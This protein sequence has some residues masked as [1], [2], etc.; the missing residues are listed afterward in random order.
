MNLRTL[1]GTVGTFTLVLAVVVSAAAAGPA[2]LAPEGTTTDPG[3]PSSFSPAST[4]VQTAP[5]SGSVRVD[6][7]SHGDVVVLDVAHGNDQ[8]AEQVRTLE[9]VLVENGY[10]VRFHGASSGSTAA[11]AQ[12]GSEKPELN[13]SLRG[14]D[15]YVVV[16]PAQPFTPADATSVERFAEAGGRVLVLTDPKSQSLAGVLLTSLFG[17]SLD[18]SPSPLAPMSSRHGL[19]VGSGYLYD[20]DTHDGNFQTVYAN[21]ASGTLARGVDRV[22]LHRAAPVAAAPDATVALR[23]DATTEQS[24]GGP[25][26]QYD[27]AARSGNVALVGDTS[28]LETE[29]LRDADNEV[30]VGNLVEFLVSGTAATDT[31]GASPDDDA[32]PE[33]RPDTGGGVNGTTTA[34]RGE[35]TN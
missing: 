31:L 6:A 27:V 30:F 3:L 34:P 8:S 14:A 4:S 24:D 23:T 20:M 28:F 2:L 18:G 16:N 1:V 19:G 11:P 12:R 7:E 10:Q 26:R 33:S 29:N 13:A 15:A 21:G 32:P 9:Q 25:K 5:E 35:G 22:S 17:G